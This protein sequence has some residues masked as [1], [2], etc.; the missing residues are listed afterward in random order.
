MT[1]PWLTIVGIGEE[2]GGGIDPQAWPMIGIAELL[3]GGERHLATVP[4]AASRAK[5]LLWAQPF[6]ATVD[7]ILAHRGRPAVVLASGDPME[8][9]IGA[10]L[11]RHLSAREMTILPHPGAFSLAA[12][13]LAWPLHAVRRTT[14]HGRPLERLALFLQPG[15]RLL[16]LSRDGET[17]IEVARWLE[18]QG[19]G[20]SEIT[21]L[22]RLGGDS[23]RIVTGTAVDFPAQAFADLNTLAIHF[24]PSAAA[25]VL[26]RLAGLPDSCF[27]N[28]GQLTKQD[29][30]AATLAKLAPC[31]GELL[32]DVGAGCGS[33]AIEWM[34]ADEGMR[35]VAIER[36]AARVA[37]IARNASNL[38]V[39]DIRI[40]EG[41]AP[42]ALVDLGPPDAVFIGGG[43]SAETIDRCW[44]A[45][46]PGGRL[47][48]NAVT[49]EGEGV[50]F[51]AHK[52]LGGSLTR[53]AVSHVG[54]LADHHVW[55]AAMPVCQ[56]VVSKPR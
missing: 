27:E 56:F 50:L 42:E 46:N 44:A 17:P 24:R 41:S 33:I 32:W 20:A 22:E 43:I 47:V 31:A 18:A 54:P 37:M 26:S 55:R 16:A 9:G 40:I 34:R 52:R 39:P 51:A 21:V 10:T 19:W 5:R 12:A 35:A 7:A 29:V 6:A 23:E 3:V 4:E 8:W 25:R 13:R 49:V 48:A 28:D 15:T 53:I 30:R 45:L 2:A 14:L 11:S 38:G 1:G 36:V